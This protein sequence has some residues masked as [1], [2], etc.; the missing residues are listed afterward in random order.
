[1]RRPQIKGQIDARGGGPDHFLDSNELPIV[2]SADPPRKGR[3][4]WDV[5][6]QMQV[7]ANISQQLAEMLRLYLL[8]RYAIGN[9]PPEEQGAKMVV[10]E[11]RSSPLLHCICVEITVI[12]LP[13]LQYGP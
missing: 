10:V 7:V 6:F 9:D 1:V 8:E 2:R 11:R 13:L 12:Q 3:P 5:I 4:T